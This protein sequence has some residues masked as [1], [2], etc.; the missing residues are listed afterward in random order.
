MQTLECQTTGKAGRKGCFVSV[1]AE[2]NSNATF[3][4]FACSCLR[5]YKRPEVYRTLCILLNSIASFYFGRIQN[6][7]FYSIFETSIVGLL[8]LLEQFGAQS[9]VIF[10][11]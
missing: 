6:L 9:G 11:Q 7:S 3:E 5:M 10:D 2:R 1:H 8:D 4:Y